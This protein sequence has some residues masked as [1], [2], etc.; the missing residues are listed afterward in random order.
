M[1]RIEADYT[2]YEL[3]NHMKKN[4]NKMKAQELRQLVKR[5]N[6]LNNNMVL[7]EVFLVI[8]ILVFLLLELDQDSEMF[9]DKVRDDD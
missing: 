8:K 1:L 2:F 4:S 7:S 3:K 9:G 6:K 5:L